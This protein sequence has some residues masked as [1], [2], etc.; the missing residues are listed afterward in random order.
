M[1][2]R[3][4]DKMHIVRLGDGGESLRHL[5]VGVAGA[6]HA[7]AHLAH[8]TSSSHQVVDLGLLGGVHVLVGNHN[9]V[10]SE[11]SE[12]INVA[13]KI[14]LDDVSRS[15]SDGVLGIGRVVTDNIIDR[16][17]GGERDT[18]LDVLAL[19]DLRALLL[20]E[21]ITKGADVR[22]ELS[23]DTLRLTSE[24]RR[25]PASERPSGTCSR[26]QQQSCISGQRWGWK[27]P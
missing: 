10:G 11:S 6:D 7:L 19:E 17:A 24:Q 20:N 2:Q 26:F 15:K 4:L 8:Q 3:A 18:L 13:A 1:H 14:H 27:D 16:D 9:G 25:L 5:G 23:S 21:A 22:N 12:A